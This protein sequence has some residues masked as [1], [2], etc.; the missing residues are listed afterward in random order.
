[1]FSFDI[2]S[3]ELRLDFNFE[4]C[5]LLKKQDDIDSL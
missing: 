3:P 5:E 2:E 1:M 4:E